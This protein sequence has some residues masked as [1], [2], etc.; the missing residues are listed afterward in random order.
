[1]RDASKD[2]DGFYFCSASNGFGSDIGKLI[3][4]T[5]QREFKSL[6]LS[7]P[8]E[9]LSFF[10]LSRIVLL[11][12]SHFRDTLFRRFFYFAFLRKSYNWLSTA[13]S[14]NSLSAWAQRSDLLFV[15]SFLIL[16]FARSF[17]SLLDLTGIL[18]S[19]P[20]STL[21]LL[22]LQLLGHCHIPRASPF[23]YAN[24]DRINKKERGCGTRM[25][26]RWWRAHWNCLVERRRQSDY[27][28]NWTF[29]VSL[30]TL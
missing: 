20:L 28:S 23:C 5:L 26:C 2:T 27:G 9:S 24:E 15:C 10:I 8:S 4:L 30:Q 19:L 25:S 7:Q 1:M 16:F 14:S 17:F 18:L 22:L 29:H 6:F 11:S 13:S 21:L 3:R 12:I